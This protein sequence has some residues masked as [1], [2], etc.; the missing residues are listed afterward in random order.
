MSDVKFNPGDKVTPI[1]SRWRGHDV[2]TAG[3]QYTVKKVIAGLSVVLNEDA[4]EYGWSIDNFKRYFDPSTLDW[5]G[6]RLY[7]VVPDNAE[8]LAAANYVASEL[9]RSACEGFHFNA[10]E[11]NI[12][13]DRLAAALAQPT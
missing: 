10:V 12:L 5:E 3:T 4:N 8:F 11:L 9:R 2:I 6:A 1:E 7:P 13:A